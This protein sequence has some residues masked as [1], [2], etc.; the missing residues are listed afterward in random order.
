MTVSTKRDYFLLIIDLEGSTGLA[1]RKIKEATHSLSR[2]L[3]SL[4]ATHKA[5][6]ALPLKQHYGDEVAA[7]LHSPRAIYEIVDAVR[8]VVHPYTRVRFVVTRGRIGQAAKD[9]SLVGGSVFKDAVRLMSMLKKKSS[10]ASW[11]IGGPVEQSVLQALS[12]MSDGL[13]DDLTEFRY[14]I[15]RLL[16]TG[17][18]QSQVA[19]TMK[20]HP[21]SISSAVAGGHLRALI[22]GEEAIRAVL[23]SFQ[24][25][26]VDV[27]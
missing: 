2:V 19:R 20:R 25:K 26:M 8:D 21:Q 12:D 4:S 7:L 14:R 13:I 1:P 16:R 11:Q 18:P 24:S 9:I 6:L 17:S 3:A 27:R 15:W 23:G 22:E 10:R 5:D